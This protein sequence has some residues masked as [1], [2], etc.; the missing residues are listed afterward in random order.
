[1]PQKQKYQTDREKQRAYRE[2]KRNAQSVTFHP[3]RQ[4][5]IDALEAIRKLEAFAVDD[6]FKERS[7]VDHFLHMVVRAAADA[8]S[9]S[10]YHRR[11]AS[12]IWTQS[13][14]LKENSYE[15]LPFS[16]SGI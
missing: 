15:E 6:G 8:E 11:T 12:G 1:M 5:Y 9:D 7:T 16:I 3:A 14:L 2:R 4:A 13:P 10:L